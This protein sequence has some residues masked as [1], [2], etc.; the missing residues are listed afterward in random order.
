MNQQSGFQAVITKVVGQHK[1][2]ILWAE[3]IGILLAFL[4]GI[5]WYALQIGYILPFGALLLAMVYFLMAFTPLN[6]E[7]MND[8]KLMD[9]PVVLIFVNKLAFLALSI[10]VLGMIFLI[11]HMPGASVMCFVGVT[12]LVLVLLFWLSTRKGLNAQVLRT[13]FALRVGLGLLIL[14]VFLVMV[15]L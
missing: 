6:I 11:W 14:V 8:A 9:S 15:Y 3:K 1:T 12:N 4:G 2:K 5:L 10:S 13:P 7:N